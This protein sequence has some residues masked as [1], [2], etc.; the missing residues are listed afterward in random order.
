MVSKKQLVV[1]NFH[2]LFVLVEF[3]FIAGNATVTFGPTDTKAN[4]TIIINDDSRLEATEQFNLTLLIPNATKSVGVEKGAPV[5]STGVILN[6][7]S[8]E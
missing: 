5:F 4:T 8:K 3:D 6:D 1:S 7:D 2:E